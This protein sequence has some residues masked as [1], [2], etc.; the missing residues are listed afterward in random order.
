MNGFRRRQRMF[1]LAEPRSG[2]SWLMET[3]GSHAEIQLLGEILNQA[4]NSDIKKYQ[5]GS[6]AD[7]R[8]CLDYL[9]GI[10]N[11]R[12]NQK[13][14]FG[15]CKILL[16]QLDLI[17]HDFPAFFLDFYHDAS[18]IF[19]YRAN[20]VAAQISLQIAHRH[21]AWHA[22]QVDEIA[23]KK[24]RIPPRF[25][26]ANLKKCLWRRER[27]RSMLAAAGSRVHA[28]SYEELFGDE[29]RSLDKIFAFLHLADRHVVRSGERRGN[30]FQPQ[31]TLENYS[32]IEMSLQSHPDFHGML[33]NAQG[34]DFPA[35]RRLTH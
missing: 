18:F 15:G 25:L 28:L 30:P 11:A 34:G 9:E 20:I 21:D 4:Q 27:I 33:L 31:E 17:G 23:L 32:E 13:G 12:T 29:K 3:L 5:N 10:L 35:A 6:A 24:V 16:N 26:I 8:G 7:F 22:K 19:L 2:S 14:R 1:I